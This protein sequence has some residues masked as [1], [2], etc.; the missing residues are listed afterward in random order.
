MK[1]LNFFSNKHFRYMAALCLLL[2][3][4]FGNAWGDTYNFLTPSI[5]EIPGSWST[6][7]G[8][9]TIN[10]ISWTY[11]SATYIALDNSHTKIQIGSK[12]NPQTT[13][14]TIQTAISNFGSGKKVTAISITAYTTAT[15]AT[16]DISAGGSSVK[17]GSLTTSSSTYSATSL[18]VTSGDIV[19][20]MTGSSNSQGMYL[21]NISVTYEDAGGSTYTVV[22]I[23]PQKFALR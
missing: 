22:Y 14:W 21:S 4:G 11:S 7:G 12:K 8:S 23:D 17:S 5:T 2:S 6:S 9:K 15:T 19:V 16:Y 13:D 20:T 3:F 18:N 10:S 1:H